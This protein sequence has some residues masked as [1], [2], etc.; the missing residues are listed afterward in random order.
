MAITDMKVNENQERLLKAIG[1]A[2]ERHTALTP[3]PIDMIIGV[4]AFTTGA[5]IGQAKHRSQRFELRK[6]AEANM[7]NGTQMITGAKPSG[8]IMP[9][10]VLQ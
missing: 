10:G 3:M 8:L 4:L 1:E 2:I 6:M 7:D 5:A 9:A